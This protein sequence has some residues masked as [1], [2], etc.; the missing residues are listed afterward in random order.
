MRDGSGG[1]T[2][3]WWVGWAIPRRSSRMVSASL[4]VDWPF[5]AAS[6]ARALAASA[7]ASSWSAVCHGEE[8]AGGHVSD[9]SPGCALT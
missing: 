9:A 1:D 8:E 3:T 7:R 4:K 2:W 6:S 5:L